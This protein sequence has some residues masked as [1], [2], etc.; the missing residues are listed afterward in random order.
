[1][2]QVDR[3]LNMGTIQKYDI[4]MLIVLSIIIAL[5]IHCFGQTSPQSTTAC[6]YVKRDHAQ[7]PSLYKYHGRDVPTTAKFFIFT[8]DKDTNECTINT[9]RLINFYDFPS[10][11]IVTAMFV[12]ACKGPLHIVLTNIHALQDAFYNVIGYFQVQGCLF[13]MKSLHQFSDA[14]DMRVVTF[15]G[16]PIYNITDTSASTKRGLLGNAVALSIDKK[17]DNNNGDISEFLEGDHTFP[18][19]KEVS[20]LHL[21]W[22]ELPSGMK[23]IFPFLESLDIQNNNFTKPP[24]LFPWNNAISRLPR[25]LSRSRYFQSQYSLSLHIDIQPNVYRRFYNLDNNN[26]ETLSEYKFHGTLHMISVN[27]NSLLEVGEECFR[28]VTDLQHVSLANNLLTSL[29][30]G[31]FR[32]LTSLRHLDISNN[33][34]EKLPDGIFDDSSNLIYINLASNRISSLGKGLFLKLLSL[35]TLLLDRN[36]IAVIN[37]ASFPLHSIS[38]SHIGLSSNPLRQIPNIAFYIR[39]LRL[40]D[41][42]NTSITLANSSGLINEIDSTLLLESVVESASD[43]TVDIF[44][45]PSQLREIDLS[46]NSIESIDLSGNISE[47]CKL[48]LII[49]LIHFHFN[50]NNNP[51]RCD[52][53]IIPL[54]NVI[55]QYTHNATITR[56]DYF[57]REWTCVSPK[58]LDGRKLLMVKKEET[59]CRVNVSSCPVNCLCHQWSVSHIIIVDCRDTGMMSLPLRLPG[60]VLDLWF[61]RNNITKIEKRHYFPR[62]RTLSLNSNQISRIEGN[63]VLRLN[64]V[65]NLHLSSNNLI[66]LPKQIQYLQLAELSITDNPFLCDCHS[67][68]MRTWVERNKDVVLDFTAVSCNTQLGT[69]RPILKVPTSEFVCKHDF[70]VRKHVII[71]ATA[72]CVS[73]SLILLVVALVCI[74]RLEVK[75]FLY[76]Y[77]GVRPFDREN[78]QVNKPIDLVVIHSPQTQAWVTDNVSPLAARKN[79]PNF[80]IFS[81]CADCVAG[82]SFQDNIASLVEHARKV[83]IVLSKD[84]LDDNKLQMAWTEIKKEIPDSGTGFIQFVTDDVLAADLPDPEMIRVMKH[85]RYL[86]I[87]ERFMKNK[88]YYYMPLSKTYGE[89]PSRPMLQRLLEKRNKNLECINSSNISIFLSYSEDILTFI[90]TSLCPQLQNCGYSLCLPDKDFTL[91][92]AKEENI[93]QAVTNSQ[94]TLFIVSGNTFVDEWSLFTFRAAAQRSLREKYNHLIVVLTHSVKADSVRDEELRHYLKLHVSLS[95][96]DENFLRKLRFSVR[97]VQSSAHQVNGDLLIATNNDI[98]LTNV[99]LNV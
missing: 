37:E 33:F 31:L 65:E 99:V 57:F 35:E 8:N 28:N 3:R 54:I 97:Q 22:R 51:L 12:F 81:I 52:C 4:L 44:E 75:V 50:L 90:I 91:G 93:L 82:F 77:L 67:L 5:P 58:A 59:Y 74:Y 20:F 11:Q 71:P 61:Q 78:R 39:S 42:K 19:M 10:E 24:D 64:N 62:V 48:K 96:D 85:T 89:T 87:N 86:S 55:Q 69:A 30:G 94:H 38:L 80:H 7:F 34:I 56:N 2:L 40:I 49:L 68:W 32:G 17:S 46:E 18:E 27:N 45:R 66:G 9:T 47:S 23:Q 76:I 21:D 88:L 63:A 14:F 84:F 15:A 70:D 92:A 36:N 83:L 43:S 16:V 79:L 25:N 41:L 1:M 72:S 26:I 95:L 53:G 13:D 6:R 73:V 98:A 29:P 60:G